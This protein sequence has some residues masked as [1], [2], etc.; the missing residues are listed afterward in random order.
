MKKSLGQHLLTDENYIHE[1]ITSIPKN[2][3]FAT[4]LELGPGMGAL[5]EHLL[6]LDHPN[7]IH[8]ELD[9]RFVSLLRKNFPQLKDSLIHADFLKVDLNLICKSPVCLV[10][11]FPY[12]ISSQ[13]MFKVI[14]NREIIQAGIGMF[15]K[16]VALRLTS[17]HGSKSYGILSVFLNAFYDT[18]LLFEIPPQAFRPPPKVVSAVI[19]FKRNDRKELGCSE[20]LFRS[21]VKMA[22][23]QRRKMLRNTLKLYLPYLD[24]EYHEKR[25]E[26][27]SIDDYLKICNKIEAENE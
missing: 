20:K 14:E 18:E 23:A 9:D 7:L 11:N 21:V 26:H 1:I 25:P 10:G 2:D 16:E 6:A 27:L 12:N 15:Q 13:I 17:A 22:F 5:T 4:L 3:K 19:R 24:E 8:I